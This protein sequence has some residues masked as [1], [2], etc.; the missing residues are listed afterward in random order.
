MPH[1]SQGH[2]DSL[3]WGKDI[4]GKYWYARFYCPIHKHEVEIN[5]HV[6][7]VAPG[8]IASLQDVPNKSF[9]N[10]IHHLCYF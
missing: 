9:G 8:Q 4:S 2:G 3:D 7:C 10:S 1:K 5:G 6:D